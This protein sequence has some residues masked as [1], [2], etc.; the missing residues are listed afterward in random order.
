[1]LR[2]CVIN[3]WAVYQE[4]KKCLSESFN[5]VLFFPE[6]SPVGNEDPSSSSGSELLL[7]AIWTFTKMWFPPNILSH[8]S[9]EQQNVPH[10]ALDHLIQ[11]QDAHW[12]ISQLTQRQD[13]RRRRTNGSQSE[14]R[15]LYAFSPP[16]KRKNSRFNGCKI[17][18]GKHIN[19]MMFCKICCLYSEKQA[20]RRK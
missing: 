10:P 11:I 9:A 15:S 17:A 4:L 14:E 19:K 3:I 1:M 13:C 7:G 6:L 12:R 20:L 2:F 18:K 16:R 8:V 5:C